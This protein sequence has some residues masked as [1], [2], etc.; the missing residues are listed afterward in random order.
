MRWSMCQE[1]G[2]VL[3]EPSVIALKALNG[4]DQVRAVGADAKLLIG[5]TGENIRTLRPLSDGVIS[6]LS[7]I[8]R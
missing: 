3:D 5:R 6:A 8:V 7:Y 4:V 2:I 1:R